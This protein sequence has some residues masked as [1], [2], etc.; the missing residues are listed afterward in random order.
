VH[1]ID[2]GKGDVEMKIVYVGPVEKEDEDGG[3]GDVEMKIVY[4]GPVEKEDEEER[5]APAVSDRSKVAVEMGVDTALGAKMVKPDNGIEF[6]NNTVSKTFKNYGSI[7]QTP[8]QNEIDE[9]KHIHLLNVARSFMFCRKGGIPL[10]MCH[11]YDLNVTY[12][13]NGFPP[14]TNV[15]LPHIF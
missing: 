12:L 2:G 13:I 6:V 9:R 4:V 3:K 11:D 8:Q 1:D 7:H 5:D 10:Y 14:W 15:A